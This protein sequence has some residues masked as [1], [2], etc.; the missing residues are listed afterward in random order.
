MY[1]SNQDLKDDVHLRLGDLYM[2]L[3]SQY[4]IHS[5]G[6]YHWIDIAIEEYLLT[7]H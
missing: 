3:A 4:P 7:K 1:L 5:Q 2:D 6:Y